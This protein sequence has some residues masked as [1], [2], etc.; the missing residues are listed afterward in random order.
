MNDTDNVAYL[1]PNGVF[2]GGNN[3]AV[4]LN[5]VPIY[6][7]S[8]F[9]TVKGDAVTISNSNQVAFHGGNASETGVYV[10]NGLTTSVYASSITSPTLNGFN[11]P[12]IN[13]FGEVVFE[14]GRNGI[15]GR[16]LYD[17]PNPQ[18]DTV[19]QTLKYSW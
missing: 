12:D 10:G 2:N 8:T 18:T 5:S 11:Y 17:G 13:N 9:I 3:Q 14:A 16:G 6:D 4:Y 1:A 7:Q 19:I 15:A